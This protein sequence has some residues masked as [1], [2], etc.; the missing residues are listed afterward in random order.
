[1]VL[2]MVVLVFLASFSS[3][4]FGFSPQFVPYG[5]P[6]DS[7]LGHGA[8][9]APFRLKDLAAAFFQI[10][11]ND[12]LSEPCTESFPK[13]RVELLS[14]PTSK[15]TVT[16]KRIECHLEE[17]GATCEWRGLEE[18]NFIDDPK[19]HFK[20]GKDVPLEQ[21]LAVVRL[22]RAGN[23]DYQGRSIQS[24]WLNLPVREVKRYGKALRLTLIGC[25]CT[26]EATVQP[27]KSGHSLEV[28]RIEAFDGL[29][30]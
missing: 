13:V 21:A 22:F 26:A 9:L 7:S 30:V 24:R 8:V 23:F 27:V 2:R 15:N 18:Q 28:L 12:V 14:E 5:E 4:I 20:V 17:T 29:C 1:M 11:A 16:V 19:N 25:A 10:S 6:T 3:A